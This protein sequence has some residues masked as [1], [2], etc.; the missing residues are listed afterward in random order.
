MLKA[1]AWGGGA[2]SGQLHGLKIVAVAVVA[3]AVWGMARSLCTDVA[4]VTIA[5]FAAC[6]AM[7]WPN[8][9]GQ[10]AV[11]TGSAITGLILLKPPGS[12]QGKSCRFQSAERPGW[13]RW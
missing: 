10:I 7:L 2:P 12:L 6:T 13:L 5:L 9:I 1:G 8:A 3:Q 11:I 4:R